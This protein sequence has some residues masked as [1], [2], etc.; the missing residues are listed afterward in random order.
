MGDIVISDKA[1]KM[2]G[3][4]SVNQPSAIYLVELALDMCRQV[5]ASDVSFVVEVFQGEGFDQYVKMYASYV[6]S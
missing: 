3:E 6:K 4:L 2:A 1:P 5:L